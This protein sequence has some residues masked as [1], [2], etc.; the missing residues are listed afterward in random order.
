MLAQVLHPLRT[1]VEVLSAEES[2]RRMALGVALGMVLGLV[3]KGNLSAAVLLGVVLSVRVNLPAALASAGLF[4]W[5][6]SWIDPFT[7]HLGMRLLTQPWVQPIG[8]YLYDLP[9]FPWT[10]L[11]NTIV[12]GSLMLGLV[13]FY[14]TYFLVGQTC[15]RYRPWL[16]ERLERYRVADALAVAAATEGRRVR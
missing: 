6:A 13:L 10:A 9:V 7:H 8:A 11:N 12:F 3:P 2:P 16:V 14:P 5:V 1:L 15:Q 4:T